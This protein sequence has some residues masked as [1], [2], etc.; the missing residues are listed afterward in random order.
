[1]RCCALGA[2][3]SGPFAAAALLLGG[4]VPAYREPAAPAGGQLA[5]REDAAAP[6][7][8]FA[9]ET[10]EEAADKPQRAI[11]THWV[12]G[13]GP[14]LRAW[15]DVRLADGLLAGYDLD[16]ATSDEYAP[17]LMCLRLNVDGGGRPLDF[18]LELEDARALD[19]PLPA[20]AVENRFDVAQA[21]MTLSGPGAAW[22]LR[23]GR[24]RPDIGTGRLVG[25]EPVLRVG[26]AVDGAWFSAADMFWYDRPYRW[27]ERVDVFAG[28]Q[29]VN[30]PSRP[31]WNQ[32]SHFQA[33]ADLA[34][35]RRYPVEIGGGLLFSSSLGDEAGETG[36]GP[37][38][39][40]TAAARASGGGLKRGFEFAVEGL[41]Q[42]GLL[43]GEPQFG[44]GLFG[45]LGHT[46]VTPWRPRVVLGLYRGS[47][48]RDAA[49]GRSGRLVLPLGG[50]SLDES[51]LLGRTG[52]PNTGSFQVRLDV[53][54]HEKVRVSC[55]ARQFYL[56]SRTD[57][58]YDALGQEVARDVTGAAGSGLGFEADGWVD[59][60]VRA[61]FRVRGGYGWFRPGRM[62]RSL[63]LAEDTDSLFV[64]LRTFF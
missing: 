30:Q 47:G 51:G 2:S 8:P 9:Y 14:G 34:S 11:Y 48:D 52:W 55:A 37:S 59:V 26:R 33:A 38:R 6:A 16:A 42:G 61:G 56:D 7:G 5:V 63:G 1:M 28:W 49:D 3:L 45:L 35:R 17:M 24:F 25:E 23:I 57:G 22:R 39:V 32:W 54:P 64:E 12:R 44:W 41:L 19:T 21:Y 15:W 29:V 18:R 20:G 36:S 53:R 46:F 50:M 27:G 10:P 58:W 31:N 4:C 13:E 43:G 40:I 62:P 60:Q